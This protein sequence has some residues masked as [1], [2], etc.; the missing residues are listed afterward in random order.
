MSGYWM[1]ESDNGSSLPTTFN[2]PWGKYK[3]LRLPLSL[4]VSVDVF[5]ERLNAGLKEVKGITG[6]VDDILTGEVDSKDHDVNLLQL[7]ETARM[8]G[9]K[10]NP[11]KLQFKTTKCDFFGQTITPKDMKVNDKRPRPSNR[12]KHQRTRKLCRVSREWSIIWSATQPSWRDY[13][14]HSNRCFGKKRNG[15]RTL[16][17]KMPSMPSKTSSPGPQYSRTLTGKK[18]TLFRLTLPCKD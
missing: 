11:K 10:F 9:I 17:I 14:N 3:W 13:S 16:S 5:Q 8:N 1:V 15:P 6:C 4:K 18:N 7:L 2:T 12:W